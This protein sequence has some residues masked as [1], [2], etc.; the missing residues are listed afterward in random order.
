ML[1]SSAT[2]IADLAVCTARRQCGAD[3]SVSRLLYCIRFYSLGLYNE[4]SPLS[5][6]VPCFG[7]GPHLP[8]LLQLPPVQK[9]YHHRQGVWDGRVMGRG[10]AIGD[11]VE[12]GR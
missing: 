3:M 11:R 5:L 1:E 10:M 12:D 9:A 2:A 6:Q 7:A 8:P 4:R